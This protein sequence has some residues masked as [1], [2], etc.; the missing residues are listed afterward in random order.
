MCQGVGGREE[1][2]KTADMEVW[3]QLVCVCV[4]VKI[5]LAICLCISLS[6]GAFFSMISLHVQ[7]IRLADTVE[8][9]FVVCAL[10]ISLGKKRGVL[11][12]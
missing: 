4:L 3:G 1:P 11:N 6:I 10:Q 2:L 7:D 12:L 5:C 8:S 9:H